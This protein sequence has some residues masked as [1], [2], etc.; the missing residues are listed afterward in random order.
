MWLP[1]SSAMGSAGIKSHSFICDENEDNLALNIVW[2][3]LCK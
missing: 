1:V 2:K 3:T